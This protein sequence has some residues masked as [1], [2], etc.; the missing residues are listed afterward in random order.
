[1]ADAEWK[2]YKED[3]IKVIK[4][5]LH[6]MTDKVVEDL[7]PLAKSWLSPPEL[8]LNSIDYTSEGYDPTQAAYIITSK[9]PDNPA[10]LSF[11]INA[12]KKSPMINPA[13]VIKD[14][15]KTNVSLTLNGKLMKK[16]EDY[17]IGYHQTFNGYDLIIWL[18]KQSES[19]VNMLIE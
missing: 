15:G 2:P 17:R 6:G 12:S 10:P 18:E 9:T 1:M 19:T 4:I 14:W 11:T 16:S 3:G 7:V 8:S 5:M 13:F